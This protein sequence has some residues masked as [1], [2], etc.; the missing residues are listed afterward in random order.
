M[1][2]VKGRS[3]IGFKLLL[4]NKKDAYLF[5]MTSSYSFLVPKLQFGNESLDAHPFGCAA[6]CQRPDDEP[7]DARHDAGASVDAEHRGVPKLQLGNQR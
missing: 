3:A 5:F 6:E 4:R 2:Y 7:G 1:V